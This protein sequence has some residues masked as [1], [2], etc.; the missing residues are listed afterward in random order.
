MAVV[1]DRIVDSRQ[2]SDEILG[3]GRERRCRQDQQVALPERRQLL[4]HVLVD[5]RPRGDD[6]DHKLPVSAV[7]KRSRRIGNLDDLERPLGIQFIDQQVQRPAPVVMVEQMTVVGP[8]PCKCSERAFTVGC[9]VG[10]GNPDREHGVS[11][12]THRT[13]TVRENTQN[14]NFFQT[15][16]SRGR[17]GREV[18]DCQIPA[19]GSA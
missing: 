5:P 15:F 17:I 16:D 11:E 10:V 1:D 9:L 2:L 4:D 18:L 7:D 6:L 12:R 19:L 13:N 3:G 14:T 8:T